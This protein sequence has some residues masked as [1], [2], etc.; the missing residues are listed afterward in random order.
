MTTTRSQ[1]ALNGTIRPSRSE[2]QVSEKKENIFLFVPNLIGTVE[3]HLRFLGYLADRATHRLL[4]YYPRNLF[5]L[6]HASPPAYL[7][8]PLLHLLYTRCLRRLYR[9]SPGTIHTLW[10]GIGYDNGPMYHCESSCI[11]SVRISA[12]LDHL[13]GLN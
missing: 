4:T 2:G 9:T 8:P 5:P 10:C 1:S 12:L 7:L 11:S 3:S 6:L 13:P